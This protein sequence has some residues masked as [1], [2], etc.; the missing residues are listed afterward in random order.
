MGIQG[1]SRSDCEVIIYLYERYGILQTLQMLDGVFA[2]ALYDTNINK[3]YL[4][5]D[6]FGIRPIFLRKIYSTFNHPFIP[7]ETYLFASTMKSIVRL[8]LDSEYN[9]INQVTPG[10]YSMFSF[11]SDDIFMLKKHNIS[12][13][14]IAP[15][16]FKTK[17]V[18]TYN[19]R[20]TCIFKSYRCIKYINK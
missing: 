11:N 16:P 17:R 9:K 14:N 4:A 12:F 6:R 19:W 7:T 8:G 18:N 20:R 15:G 5:R 10:T 3:I 2:F 13:I 1:K